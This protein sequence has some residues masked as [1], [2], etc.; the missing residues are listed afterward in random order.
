MKLGTTAVFLFASLYASLGS[1]QSFRLVS[2]DSIQLGLVPGGAFLYH[3]I[4]IENLL[5]DSIYIFD[6]PDPT[7]ESTGYTTLLKA[8]SVDEEDVVIAPRGQQEVMT[9]SMMED[10]GPFYATS[11]LSRAW[12]WEDSVELDIPYHV[13]GHATFAGNGP[14]WDD[15]DQDYTIFPDQTVGAPLFF[16]FDEVTPV[17]INYFNTTGKPIQVNDVSLWKGGGTKITSITPGTPPFTLQ[18]GEVMRI[19]TELAELDGY[20][21]DHLIVQTGEVYDMRRYQIM[22]AN[23]EASVN[24]SPA[25]SVDLR[26]YPNPAAGPLNI[27]LTGLTNAT[28]ELIDILGN[29]VLRAKSDGELRVA[30]ATL[31]LQPGPYSLRIHGVDTSGLRRTLTRMFMK[32][33]P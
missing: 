27:E 19:E 7:F 3:P 25:A 4:V 21:Y 22:P 9:V 14:Y 17:K 20:P 1:A 8:L 31:D 11:T 10:E 5:D 23:A 28:F 24:R 29:I 18:P 15:Y 33:E 26:V 16:F 32:L 2:E 12:G 13:F 6:N 30:M